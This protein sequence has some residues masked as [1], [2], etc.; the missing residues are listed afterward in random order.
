[1]DIILTLDY[2]LFLGENTGTVDSCLIKPM[3]LLESTAH[4]D[5]PIKYTIF[6][7]AVYLYKLNTYKDKYPSV[8]ADLN[9][10]SQHLTSL[11]SAGHDIQLHVHPHWYYS[12]Y[13][14]RNWILDSEHYKLSDISFD[15][16]LLIFKESKTILDSIL[17]KKT[18]IFRAGG[19]SSQPTSL[20]VTLF[21]ENGIKADS[22]VC[23][24]MCYFSSHQEYD[25][26]DTPRKDIWNFKDNICKESEDKKGVLE[27]PISTYC[28]SPLF[29]WNYVISRVFKSTKHKLYGDGKSVRT[30]QES[31]KERL[32]KKSIGL[33]T[34][35]G[36][37]ISYL[38]DAYNRYKKEGHRYFCIIGHPKLATPYS[39][40]KFNEFCS[41][42]YRKGDKFITIS[43]LCKGV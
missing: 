14:G 18:T 42:V 17:G 30:T 28:L 5:I 29:W 26:R 31:I 24:G 25:Y 2:E 6:V 22:S 20:L 39:I 34:I 38:I 27:V 36:Y 32:T 7:D 13:N 8:K 15:D 35:D 37:K 10:I 33:V 4:I 11:Q 16:A 1:M 3:E 19:F 21:N 9:K 43:E 40:R 41:Y 23:P 12:V